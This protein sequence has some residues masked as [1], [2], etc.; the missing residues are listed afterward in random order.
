MS[1]TDRC[2]SFHRWID[3]QATT[4]SQTGLGKT[5]ESD[6]GTALAI[7]TDLGILA[8][9]GVRHD[10]LGHR[11]KAGAPKTLTMGINDRVVLTRIR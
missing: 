5:K 3:R 7:E 4:N 10:V 1:A 2:L 8:G 6:I 11:Q 9:Q